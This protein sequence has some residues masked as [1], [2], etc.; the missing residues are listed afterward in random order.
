MT[1]DGTTGSELY[2]SLL[3]ADYVSVIAL[4]MYGR[5][6]L[7]RQYRPAIES[8]TLELPGGLLD[9]GERPE[10]AAKRELLEETGLI[11]RGHM[12]AFPPLLP[13]TGR[14]ENRL[15]GFF[16]EAEES[17]SPSWRPEPGL[18]LL[19]VYPSDLQLMIFRGEF[20]HALHIALL[21]LAMLN[22]Y[23]KLKNNE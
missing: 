21:G 6:P 3:V 15:W 13:D 19:F 18:E 23:L 7:V 8:V 11:S 22:G 5:V 9:A 20:N 17:S 10:C 1:R 12:H 14:L 16:V 2:H 4:D